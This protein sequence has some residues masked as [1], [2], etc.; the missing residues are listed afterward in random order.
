MGEGVLTSIWGISMIGSTNLLLL[1]F[2]STIYSML[3]LTTELKLL[4]VKLTGSS[5]HLNGWKDSR[6]RLCVAF[7]GP[8]Q[9]TTHFTSYGSFRS[10]VPLLFVLWTCGFVT[11][12]SNRIKEIGGVRRFMLDGSVLSFKPNLRTSNPTWKSGIEMLLATLIRKKSNSSKGFNSSIWKR[13]KGEFWTCGWL[14][15]SRPETTSKRWP[16]ERKL[17]GVKN[18]GLIGSVTETAILSSYSFANGRKSKNQ[19]SSLV[20][21]WT[22]T[23]DIQKI[24]NEVIAFY[25]RLYSSDNSLAASF[26]SWS[27][28]TLSL[29]KSNWLE[30]PFSDKEIKLAVFSLASNKAPGQDGFPIAFFQECWDIVQ[31]DIVYL[32]KEF[33]SHGKISGGLNSTFIAPS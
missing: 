2:R 18:L 25:K 19:I 6:R 28:K 24:E 5:P 21:D 20:I 1:T 32:F 10:T 7:C 4:V 11:L 31:K 16:F 12:P 30:R 27:A 14:K 3:G 17:N 8:F 13:K 29:E 15:E 26:S 33:H 23:H 22:Q 9:I